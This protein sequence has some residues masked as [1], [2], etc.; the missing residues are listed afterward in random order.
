MKISPRVILL[1]REAI[2][3]R[4]GFKG[5]K[6]ARDFGFL[7]GVRGRSGGNPDR[8]PGGSRDAAAQTMKTGF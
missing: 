2:A 4:A 5:I 3:G 8:H 7:G 1:L 6:P